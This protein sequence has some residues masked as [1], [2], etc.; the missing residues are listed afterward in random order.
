MNIKKIA[1][2]ITIVL[3]IIY[4]ENCFAVSITLDKNQ[5]KELTILFDAVVNNCEAG[6][7]KQGE[8]SND[9]LILCGITASTGSKY[10][11]HANNNGLYQVPSSYID[12]IVM[13]YFGRTVVH[14]SVPGFPF[15]KGFYSMHGGDRGEPNILRFTKI[16]S[17]GNKTYR[18]YVS[19]YETSD[20]K[21]FLKEKAI[22]QTVNY[23]GNDHFVMLELQKEWAAKGYGKK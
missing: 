8:L 23:K 19:Y 17:L 4:S 9:K 22:V 21:L 12:Y 16:E 18:V 3:S 14:K 1:K 10:A 5:T 7:F 2:F 15:N 20:K 13:K 6:Y 11:T